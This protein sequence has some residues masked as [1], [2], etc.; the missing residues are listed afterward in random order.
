MHNLHAQTSPDAELLGRD[1]PHHG[2][3]TPV[4]AQARI[5]PPS[6]QAAAGVGNASA[7]RAGATTERADQRHAVRLRANDGNPQPSRPEVRP[8][9]PPAARPPA[10]AAPRLPG[11]LRRTA[12]APAASPKTRTAAPARRRPRRSR[13]PGPSPR[14]DTRARRADRSGSTQCQTPREGAA[15]DQ[16]DAG[17]PRRDPR[18][19]PHDS[20]I[21]ESTP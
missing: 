2:R 17:T 15:P 20:R 14:P 6:T 1:P 4:A 10:A 18:A 11:P 5:V 3:N 19:K 8:L 9:Q 13:P 21:P 7:G 12:R 16:P